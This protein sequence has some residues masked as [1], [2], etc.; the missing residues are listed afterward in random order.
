M[1]NPL[2]Y[3]DKAGWEAPLKFKMLMVYLARYPLYSGFVSG[4]ERHF[5]EVCKRTGDYDAQVEVV[6]CPTGQ[7]VLNL[8]GIKT[9]MYQV[10]TPLENIL[11]KWHNIGL[12]LIYV[13]RII[14]A[15][16][17]LFSLPRDYDIICATSHFLPEVLPAV[18][19]R[20]RIPRA[21]LVVYLHHLEAEPWKARGRPLLGRIPAWMNAIV[22]LWLIKRYAHLVVTVTPTVME[23]LIARGIPEKKIKVFPN[24][25]DT[26]SIESA[27]PAEERHE[28]C[29]FGRVA[30]TKGI[31]D[32][33][34]IWDDVCR[35]NAQARV[36]IIGGN[37]EGYLSKL[38]ERIKAKDL[39]ANVLL[40]GVAPEQRK[41]ELIKACQV[42]VSPSYEEGWGIAVC[43]VLACGLPVVAYDLPAYEVFGNEA[44]IKVPVG[45]KK[46]LLEAVLTLLSDENLRRQM[47]QKAREVAGQFSWQEVAEGELT[48]LSSLALEARDV[49]LKKGALICLLGVDGTG[50]TTA[51]TGL[52]NRLEKD[53]FNYTY[54]NLNHFLFKF[55]PTRLHR[56]VGRLLVPIVEAK[57]G[58]SSPGS[59]TG[60]VNKTTM[61]LLCLALLLRLT[62][63]LIGYFIRVRPA[64]RR[65]IVVHDRYFYDYVI[66]YLD[67]CPRWLLRFYRRLIPEPDLTFFL[68]VAPEIAQARDGEYSPSF[69]PLQRR[70]YLDFA[71]ELKPEALTICNTGKPE[72]EVVS[73]LYSRVLEVIKG[74][75]ESA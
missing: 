27:A 18:I 57:A 70:R 65:S 50:K 54:L 63:S 30:P 64:A 40:H 48:L 58:R 23:D 39:E 8:N 17:L 68:D 37:G 12:S 47:G 44:M 43:E 34:D 13:M 3:R 71:K 45:D 15:I 21:K 42:G 11:G 25:I 56:M 2:Y 33:I 28:V 14:G 6:T 49:K 1:A 67:A 52:C 22:S 73:F 24:G 31:G 51:A 55:I 60:Q 5:I 26:A 19:I 9:K 20:K 29:Y 66:L 10:S 59:E 7:R 46:A 38:R 36:S 4:G 69:Y 62:D 75:T 41:Y 61:F 72:E 16:P 35:S 74:E 32:I 53:G